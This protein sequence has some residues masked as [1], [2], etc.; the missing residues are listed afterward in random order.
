MQPTPDRVLNLIAAK[1]KTQLVM[2]VNDYQKGDLMLL[3]GIIAAAA[4]RYEHDADIYVREHRA[5]RTIFLQALED[6]GARAAI[7]AEEL[8]VA[9]EGEL[10]DFR[11]SSLRQALETR[12]RLLGRLHEWATG[13]A[14]G[15]RAT[16]EAFLADHVLLHA[17]ECGPYA[18]PGV[19]ERK[20]RVLKKV[21]CP[22][23]ES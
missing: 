15:L 5:M 4:E 14:A 17:F 21:N 9:A 13:H 7:G 22:R 16:I 23:S 1:I 18:S 11:M 19:A 3:A 6:D 10:E 12:L 2:Q 8:A 20:R